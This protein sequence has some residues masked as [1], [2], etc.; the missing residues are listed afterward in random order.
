MET[1]TSIKNCFIPTENVNLATHYDL[2][3]GQ[4]YTLKGNRHTE[5]WKNFCELCEYK[6]SVKKDENDSYSYSEDSDEDEE[7]EVDAFKLAEIAKS[8]EAV[9]LTLEFEI[10]FDSEMIKKKL[11]HQ[12]Q[13]YDPE[14]IS[15]IIKNCQNTIQELYVISNDNLELVCCFSETNEDKYEYGG[16]F[17]VVRFKLQFPNLKM[18]PKKELEP[19][20]TVLIKKLKSSNLITQLQCHP[21]NNWDDIITKEHTGIYPLYLCD[22]YGYEWRDTYDHLGIIP[23]IKTVFSLTRHDDHITGNFNP[24]MEI[25]KVEFWKSMF[26]SIKYG[27]KTAKRRE[28]IISDGH[29]NSLN[30]RIRNK[31]TPDQVKCKQ[32]VSMIDKKRLNG[33]YFWIDVGKALYNTYDGENGGFRIWKGLTK[34]SDVF[35]TAQCSKLYP[36]FEIDNNLTVKT[37]GWYARKDSPI[38][39]DKW[40]VD[41]TTKAITSALTM[42]RDYEVGKVFESMFW[43]DYVCAGVKKNIWFKYERHRWNKIDGASKIRNLL[44]TSFTEALQ[45]YKETLITEIGAAGNQNNREQGDIFRTNII[46]IIRNAGNYNKKNILVRQL[47][48]LM[49]DEQFN[50]NLDKDCNIMGVRNGVIECLENKAIFRQGKPEDYVS[51]QSKTKYN[52]RMNWEHKSVKKVLYWY[53]QLY[54]AEDV[55]HY[56]QK[57]YS[58]FLQGRNVDKKLYFF[59]GDTNAGKSIIKKFFECIMGQ[60]S[61][62]LPEGVFANSKYKSS[63]GLK[64]GLAL[65]MKS[66]V[67]WVL[68][69]N[70]T[71]NGT[72]IKLGTGNDK[73]FV[74]LMGENGG[75]ET[76][77]FKTVY[78]CNMVPV[79]IAPDNALTE[80]VLIIPHLSVWSHDAP[81]SVEE[82]FKQRIFKR[83]NDFDLKLHRLASAGLWIMVQY[84]KKYKKEKLVMPASIQA[85]TD[86]Y[87]EQNDVYGSFTTDQI[88]E[89]ESDAPLKI[90]AVNMKFTSWLD[91]HYPDMDKP[92][93]GTLKYVLS[94]RWKKKGWN[95]ELEENCWYGIALRSHRA[96][97]NHFEV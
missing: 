58:S 31:D 94:Q 72:D 95:M 88:V 3:A 7:L 22:D 68:E 26:L 78:V 85:A 29:G 15:G 16:K 39:Y 5:F 25:S 67:A 32:L 92:N 56:V 64:P 34:L 74:R 86:S 83:D 11:D 79:I 97:N 50:E 24:G 4:Y 71:M 81:E 59:T 75:N 70:E 1:I 63:N 14:F 37:I 38:M 62:T 91:S 60:Y 96:T 76:P 19:F 47:A 87:W 73:L 66:N 80:R 82:Q 90:E 8:N 89:T 52:P 61:F 46:K 57:I 35:T 43:L 13:M 93:I 54:P 6:K 55:R 49:E 21:S 48:D 30:F 40:L 17:L 65:A 20:R 45:R 69:N 51:Y 84:F 44:S 9:P 41:R 27:V 23:D 36:E 12:W 18:S 33:R 42:N 10:K 28:T 77:R 2:E 53:K